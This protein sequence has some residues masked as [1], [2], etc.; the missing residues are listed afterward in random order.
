MG[1]RTAS[2]RARRRGRPA[3]SRYRTS[4]PQFS[5]AIGPRWRNARAASLRRRISWPASRRRQNCRST[6]ASM[7]NA[8]CSW[9][10]CRVRSRRPCVTCFSPNGRRRKSTACRKT[11]RSAP[12][13]SVGIIGGGTMGGGIAMSFANAGI[14]VTLIEIND[15][16]LARGLSIVEKNYAA[17]VK[18]GKLSEDKASNAGR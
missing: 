1:A 12:I 10:A 17:S 9:S 7:S 8:S 2:S 3:S 4:M 15:E 6:K 11:R 16:A 18:R 14:P 13:E 5:T